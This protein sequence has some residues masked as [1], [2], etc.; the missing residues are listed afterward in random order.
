MSETPEF[1]LTSEDVTPERPRFDGWT[2]AARKKLGVGDEWEWCS[3]EAL[4]PR[5]PE[6]DTLMELGIPNHRGPWDK[7]MW[8]GVEGRKCVIT[9]AEYRAV[10]DEYEHETGKCYL[11]AG[12]GEVLKQWSSATGCTYRTCNRCAGTGLTPNAAARAALPETGRE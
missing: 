3:M 2:V 6:C 7:Y 1:V 9:H 10:C 8:R 5:G 4:E 11:C 12:C